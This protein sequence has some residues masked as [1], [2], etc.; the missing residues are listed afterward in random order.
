MDNSALEILSSFTT[1]SSLL[2]KKALSFSDMVPD[3]IKDQAKEKSVNI[4]KLGD[5][6]NTINKLI[7][8]LPKAKAA[9]TP[10][11]NI[12]SENSL[13][14]LKKLYN[15]L[16]FD[17]IKGFIPINEDDIKK[18]LLYLINFN[19]TLIQ[20]IEIVKNLREKLQ[21]VFQSDF[22]DIEMKH[23]KSDSKFG[24]WGNFTDTKDYIDNILGDNLEFV[25]STIEELKNKDLQTFQ[26]IK[27]VKQN[28]TSSNM[29]EMESL[30]QNTSKKPEEIKNPKEVKK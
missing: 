14:D 8:S 18:H 23:S 25:F 30:L 27:N 12:T 6:V 9:D 24:F 1:C 16:N 13:S 11:W 19:K 21:V 17:K 5:V 26:Q 29:N 22:A 28:E 3:F 10:E 2:S 7:L 4:S 15:S 20:I